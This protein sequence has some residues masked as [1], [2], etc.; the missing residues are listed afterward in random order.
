MG[1]AANYAVAYL[2]NI[3]LEPMTSASTEH[4]AFDGVIKSGGVSVST[5][6]L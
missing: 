4:Q 3:K 5:N 1:K 2:K 6:Y